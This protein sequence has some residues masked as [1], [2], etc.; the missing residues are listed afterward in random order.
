MVDFTKAYF[1]LGLRILFNM[2][3]NN[4]GFN[5]HKLFNFLKPFELSLWL[6]IIASAAIISASLAIIGRLSP[7]DWHQNPP[8]DFLSWESKFQM[9]FYNSVWQSLSGILQQGDNIIC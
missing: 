4:D 8:N 3:D 2:N 9:T 1:N 6:L 7:Y 5:T